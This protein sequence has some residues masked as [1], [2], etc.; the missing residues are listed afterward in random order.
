[1]A[2]AAAVARGRPR[3]LCSGVAGGL[4]RAR[5]I[6]CAG[7]VQETPAP[8][9]IAVFS[10][11]R[12]QKWSKGKLKEKVNN[13]VLFDKVSGTLQHRAYQYIEFF[14]AHSQQWQCR[15]AAGL[16]WQRALE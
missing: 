4:Q 8:N 6:A 14:S 5:P 3:Q 7:A 2:A 12:V 16:H 9:D 13:L 15:D 10:L 1:M 11:S